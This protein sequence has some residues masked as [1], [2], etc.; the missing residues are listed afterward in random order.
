MGKPKIGAIIALDG[1]KEFKK[2]VAGCGS[3]LK[4]LESQS[5]LLELQFDGQANTLEALRK[6]HEVLNKILDAHKKKEKEIKKALDNANKSRKS[7]GR[8]L[9][10]LRAKQEE[11]TRKME[12]MKAASGT[13]NEEL[14]EQKK[15]VK[16]L[17]EAIARGERNYE[18][19]SRRI[20]RW[21]TSL[22]NAKTETIQV[23]RALETTTQ[24]LR[25]AESS[26]DGCARSIDEYGRAVREAQNS[27]VGWSEA[28]KVAVA[29]KAVGTLT[30]TIK[31]IGSAAVTAATD[32]E[33]SVNQI[34]AST[35]ASAEQMQK[36]KDTLTSV[37][38]DNFGDDLND[39]AEAVSK[40]TQNLGELNQTELKNVT[41]NAITLRDTFGF[42]YQ[43]Q[44]R[45]VKMLMDTFGISSTKAYNLIAQGAQKGL[46]K[47][48]DLLDT[49]NEYASHYKRMGVSAE[50]F[51][52][53][54]ANGTAAGTFSVDKLG[55][56]F[57]EFGIRVK[58]TANSTTEG[59]ELLGMDADEMRQKF[60]QGGE[61]AKAATEEV[62]T[63]LFGMDDQVKQNQA[64]VDLF[65]TMWEDLGKDGVQALTN[66][67]GEISMANDALT[68]IK[69]IKYDDIGNQITQIG[70]TIQMKFAKPLAKDILPKVA[71]GL[72]LVG[73]NLDVVT[74]LAIGLGSAIAIYKVGK[75]EWFSGLIAGIAKARAGMVAATA[76]T[77]GVTVAT[78][79]AT[80]A[81]KLF[82]A[83]CSMSPLAKVITVVVAA[84]AAIAAFKAITGDTNNELMQNHA[85]VKELCKNMD[86][87]TVSMD[88]NQERRK[89]AVEDT[90][91][92]W[93]ACQNMSDMLFDLAE[94]EEKSSTEKE[95]MKI[96]VDQLNEAMPNLNLTIDEQTGALNKNQEAVNGVIEAMKKKAIA[97]AME[98]QTT[99]IMKEQAQ[100]MLEVKKA[101]AEKLELDAKIEEKQ[102]QLN[103]ALYGTEEAMEGQSIAI[104]GVNDEA[105]KLSAEMAVMI[106]DREKLEKAISKGNDAVEESNQE[107]DLYLTT[108]GEMQK[109]LGDAAGAAEDMGEAVEEAGEAT[110]TLSD[111]TEDMEAVVTS[112]YEEMKNSVADSLKS[113]ETVFEEFNGGQEIST[114]EMLENLR[115]QTAGME[116][117]RDNMAL[118]AEQAGKGMS[119]NLYTY[120]AQMGPQGANAVDSLATALRDGSGEFEQICTEWEKAISLEGQ[121]AELVAGYY[122]VGTDLEDGTIRGIKDKGPEVV[123]AAKQVIQQ[124]KA[125]A[126][127][128]AQIKSPSRVWRDKIGKMLALGV[129]VGITDGGGEVKSSAVEMCQDVVQASLK[130]LDIHSPSGVFRDKVGKRIPEGV[131]VGI[132]HGKA[133]TVAASKDMAKM[134]YEQASALTK[135]LQSKGIQRLQDEKKIWQNARKQ[136]DKGTAEYKKAS[137]KIRNLDFKIKIKKQGSFGIS[138]KD[139]DGAVKTAEQYSSE[140]LAAATSWFGNY[141]KQQDVSID[142][143]ILYW[144]EIR[145]QLKKGTD[146]YKEVTYTIKK[147][148]QESK[149]EKK[150]AEKNARQEKLSASDTT[151]SQ[152][153]TYYKVSAKAEVDYWDIVR[154]QFKKGT[155]ERIEADQKYYEAK[156]NLNSQLEELNEE[157]VQN[158]AEVQEKLKS[159][160]QELTDAYNDAVKE[161]A[162]SIYSSVGLFDAFESESESGEKLLHNLKTQVAGIADWEVQ[163]RELTSR[164][165]PKGL[166]EELQEMGPEA[167]ASLHALNSLTNEQLEEYASLWEQKHSL[168][169]AEAVR[170]L[171]PMRKETE[172]Q[173]KG[174]TDSAKKE[175]SKLKTEY[176]AEIKE[177]NS[178]ISKALKKLANSTKKIGEDASA[179]LINAI[180]SGA[181]KKDTKAKLKTASDSVKN[182]LG[183]LPQAGKTIG[184]NTLKGI[185]DGLLDKK[186]ISKS[187][188]KL[189]EELK[190]E[191]QKAADIHSP[192]RLFKKEVGVQMSDGIAEGI[193]EEGKKVNSA[194]VDVVKEALASIKQQAAQQ[195][196]SLRA[197]MG[198]INS[199]AGL[200]EL[201]N[202]ISVPQVQQVN[203]S[204]DTSGLLA[205]LTDMITVLRCGFEDM[206]NMQLVTDTGALVGATGQAMGAE[207]A[208]MSRRIR[209]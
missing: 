76:A 27:T 73:D 209:G 32:M 20:E 153:K 113:C 21:Q 43:E 179:A 37:Y 46:D 91:A 31:N 186:N 141:Q 58:D 17:A 197:Y 130:E 88:E 72:E 126:Q 160:I 74:T 105:K 12:E 204:G 175:L 137:E 3:E 38:E 45:S 148:Q 103:M 191:I 51:L 185:T 83:A 193:T 140:V 114:S 110:G 161:R 29:D 41:E 168:A 178:G 10:T 109:T 34:A 78:N 181:Q 123:S 8:G 96:L 157:Y 138:K 207:L 99:E 155:A 154:K 102:K 202:L 129:A 116:K 44:L 63:A 2:A 59:F 86:E 124:A 4:E 147:L 16:E 98:E 142:K 188:K 195:Q 170:E 172:K 156:E 184:T 151:L 52:N 95:K 67:N 42:D 61:E 128:E 55:D 112:K 159:D 57:K 89:E 106:T 14:E 205:M 183:K 28:I 35:G 182:G 132:K 169:N 163:L 152:Y 77:N 149:E 70:R 118:L 167:S 104:S 101:E 190:K 165:L 187:A 194:G 53:S 150:Q 162:Q 203:A 173:I 22:N 1:E 71:D 164:G 54:L 171:E 11:A 7:V 192:S 49:I 166:M 60:A 24:H 40:T 56:A 122:K 198:E 201:N 30:D 81:T 66:L 111:A 82:N 87:L 69:D 131:E 80:V 180:K 174:L 108:A 75:S 47:N 9:E 84:T 139:K 36:Y 125:G 206:R 65:G 18:T 134:V 19:A 115:S 145:K 5:K 146:A 208:K 90:E 158:C 15:L 26:S 144:Q 93:L 117:W 177:L 199:G 121:T 25:E 6:K 176:T 133:R 135:T 13:T 33:A 92:E 85:E 120:L 79:G 119:E 143:E 94:K 136:L 62:I 50:G 189:V 107:L 200:V 39:V 64:G 97:T 100:A 68:S 23:N 48:G 127:A 196:A